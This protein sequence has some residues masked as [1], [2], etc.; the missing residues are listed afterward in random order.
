[1]N[2]IQTFTAQV[3]HKG[4]VSERQLAHVQSDE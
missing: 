4:S 1:M 3:L 2:H